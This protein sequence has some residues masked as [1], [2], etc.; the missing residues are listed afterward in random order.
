M[1]LHLKISDDELLSKW[2]NHPI[3]H[4]R[5]I[6]VR[7]SAEKPKPAETNP[8]Y[9]L[10]QI[11]N[12]I[13]W[14]DWKRRPDIPTT[15]YHAIKIETCRKFGISLARFDGQSHDTLSCAAR[16]E[17]WYRARHELGMSLPQIGKHSGQRNHTTILAGIC[18][19]EKLASMV[20]QIKKPFE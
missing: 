14:F 12:L 2:A 6:A 8:D 7:I 19:Y 18:R 4:Y 13:D 1:A 11:D 16:R 10:F 9:E 5:K 20:P 3:A 15:P 17:A